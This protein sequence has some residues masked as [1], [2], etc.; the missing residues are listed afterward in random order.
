MNRLVGFETINGKKVFNLVTEPDI[1][2]QKIVVMSHG[3]LGTSIGPAR[4]FVDFE[5][6]LLEAGFS[7]LRFD[8]PGGGNSEGDYIDSSFT[9]WVDTTTYFAKKYLELGYRVTLLGN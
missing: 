2:Q 5:Q 8:Q 6:L 1:P 4:T 7:V 3:F 9:T